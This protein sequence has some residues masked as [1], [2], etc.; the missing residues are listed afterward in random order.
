MAL[1]RLTGFSTPQDYGTYLTNLVARY[2]GA[3]AG[4]YVNAP[5]DPH[6]TIGYG[7]N[8]DAFTFTEVKGLLTYA[9]GGLT[10]LQQ[11]GMR[12]IERY[13]AGAFDA[14]VFRN[15]LLGTAGTV[16]DQAALQSIRLSLTQQQKM[17]TEMLLGGNHILAS[18][19]DARLTKALG[20]DAAI[21]D[22]LERAVLL[23]MYYNAPSL[24]GNGVRYAIRNDLRGALWY[25]IRYNHKNQ[26]ESRRIDESDRLGI[27]AKAHSVTDLVRNLHFLFNAKDQTGKDVYKTM[28]AR[29]LAYGIPSAERF[30]V[31]AA[32]L[33]AEVGRAFGHRAVLQTLT[34]GT[35]G[36]DVLT[37]RDG[38]SASGTVLART[39]KA[40]FGEAGDDRLYG[41]AGD[42]LLVGG[43]GVDVMQGGTGNDLYVVERTGDRVVEGV[44]AG[45]DTVRVAASGAY[46]IDNVEKVVLAPGVAAASFTFAS[47]GQVADASGHHL[48]VAGNAGANTIA[49][50]YTGT[51]PVD[52]AFTGGGG[53]DRFVFSSTS[54]AVADL[55]FTDIG[56]DDRIS[57]AGLHVNGRIAA[58]TLDLTGGWALKNG[59]YLISDDVKALWTTVT[60]S[61]GTVARSGAI[62]SYFGTDNDW[63]VVEIV[64]HRARLVTE[65]HGALTADMF[66]F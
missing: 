3:S 46:A 58:G 16:A 14:L 51:A 36:A 54:R 11:Q 15:I 22:S 52:I 47:P 66:L 53:S 62:D 27:V 6:P 34:D 43:S 32:V 45:V 19:I 39:N 35:S 38:L 9:L 17:L 18:S 59:R 44:R 48:T 49:V 41:G 37:G 12:L 64:D 56:P 50:T 63:F 31:E 10:A 23:S 20:I 42:D 65:F 55:W 26:N 1:S 61:G 30:P 5:Y 21:P 29:D 57:L 40:L 13:K 33:L 4:F 7:F 2:E 25:E 24:V 60:A 28:I 8:I